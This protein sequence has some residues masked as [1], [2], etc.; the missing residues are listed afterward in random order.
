MIKLLDLLRESKQVGIIYHFTTLFSIRQ[1]IA[2]YGSI[3]LDD[4]YA[5]PDAKGYFSFT[6]D[7]NLEPVKITNVRLK[8]DGNRM[9]NRYRFQ[10]FMYGGKEGEVSKKD[11]HWYEAEERID[12]NRYGGK[13]DLTPY[14]LEVTM[15]LPESVRGIYD[16][17]N[18]IW[19]KSRIENAQIAAAWF[20]QNQIPVT[21]TDINL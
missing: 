6:R 1:M 16:N 15:P 9:S 11:I 8:L 2:E 18:N 20:E 21:Y 3:V 12:A 7:S 4:K 19:A 10:P 17:P 5:S 13:I 14:I